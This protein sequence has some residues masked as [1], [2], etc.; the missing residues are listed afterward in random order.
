MIRSNL[1]GR[2]L[3]LAASATTLLLALLPG[4]R[5]LVAQQRVVTLDEARRLAS[6][7]EPGV[8]TAQGAVRNAEAQVRSAKGA[9]LP[10]LNV[11]SSGAS[12]FTEG[13]PRINSSTGEVV[14]G[15]TTQ[16]NVGMGLN[17]SLDLF[18]GFR[19]GADS[20]TAKATR[21]ASQAGLA[22]ARYEAILNVTTQYF[23]TLAAQQLV[24]VREASV[25]RANEQLQISVAKLQA[26]S[27]TR[28][29]SLR[30]VVTLGNTR[31]DLV[32]AQA[33]VAATQAEL[34]RQIGQD[35]R[36]AA[37]DDSSF[38]VVNTSV[39]TAALHEEVVASSPKVQSAD[40][41]AS[42]ARA[43]LKSSQAAYWPTVTLS[44]ATNWTG[45]SNRDYQ[46]FNQRQLA[47]GLNW[48]LFNRF[49]REQTI[50]NRISAVDAAEATAADTRRQVGSSLTAELAQLDA[51]ALKIQITQTSVAAA[52]EDLRVVGERYRLGAATILDVLTSQEALTQ[53]QVDAVTARF[54][55]VRAKAQIEALIG[56]DL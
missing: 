39:D 33:D 17:G 53:A 22:D 24:R 44:G 36:V 47:I 18:T 5:T 27:A 16:K 23:L 43:F 14:G 48:N 45:T 49:V 38:Y 29:D 50:D 2:A 4:S 40:A 31:L 10:T 7:I 26:G 13:P 8:V 42:A 15:N 46:L 54:E 1:S 28:S 3:R 25:Q 19:R 11:S 30:S 51:A 32:N 35:G 20:R 6:Q 34:A 41:A 21:D 9:Y 37:A 12:V 56:R 55:Y 52:Q